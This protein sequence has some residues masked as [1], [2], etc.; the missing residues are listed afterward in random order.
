VLKIQSFG[1]EHTRKAT[2]QKLRKNFKTITFKDAKLIDEFT[3]HTS[4]LASNIPFIGE[5]T[6]PSSVTS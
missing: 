4:T 2:A 1:V 6:S 5:T 3:V